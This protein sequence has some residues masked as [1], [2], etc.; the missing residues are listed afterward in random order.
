MS[1]L[2]YFKYKL[3][4]QTKIFHWLQ[5]FYNL[6][7][8]PTLHSEDKLANWARGREWFV[9]LSV[10]FSLWARSFDSWIVSFG[11]GAERWEGVFVKRG[12]YAEKYKWLRPKFLWVVGAIEL[13]FFLIFLPIVR[14]AFYCI[15]FILQF[16]F[17]NLNFSARQNI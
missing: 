7:N 10:L 1:F 2:F 14:I 4:K 3:Y 8:H 6:E 13:C 11:Q 17:A 5:I 15:T 12:G 16:F 9:G